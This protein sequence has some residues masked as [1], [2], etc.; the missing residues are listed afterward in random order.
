MAHL[1][2]AI[3]TSGGDANAAAHLHEW[4]FNNPMFEDV[5][6]REFWLPVVPARRDSSNDSEHLR[7][8]DQGLSDDCLVSVTGTF[9]FL[10]STLTSIYQAFLRS[11]RPLL[12]GN[13]FAPE[14]IS[15][16]EKNCLEELK[17]RRTLQFT[18]VQNVYARKRQTRP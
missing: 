7:R 16:L 8:L 3:K 5:V 2:K 1:L 18:R 11:G 4:V 12:L 6:Y 13:G 15:L 9:L 14:I 10:F 17:K